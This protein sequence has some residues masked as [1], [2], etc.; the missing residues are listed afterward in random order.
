MWPD[1]K[2]IN[3]QIVLLWCMAIYSIRIYTPLS[4]EEECKVEWLAAAAVENSESPRRFAK[5]HDLV[6]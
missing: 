5:D 2:A 3:E 4:R 1:I 6:R